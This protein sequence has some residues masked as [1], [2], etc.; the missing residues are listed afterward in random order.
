MQ[1]TLMNSRSWLNTD[2]D[3]VECMFSVPLQTQT[4][5]PKSKHERKQTNKKGQ[6]KTQNQSKEK[7]SLCKIEVNKAIALKQNEWQ[8]TIS[9]IREE[10]ETVRNKNATDQIIQKMKNS[11]D[12]LVQE[13]RNTICDISSKILGRYE[14]QARQ[15]CHSK[16]L[17]TIKRQI[18]NISNLKRQLKI[19]PEN[20]SQLNETLKYIRKEI[21]QLQGDRP[22]LKAL[23]YDLDAWRSWLDE[24][25]DETVRY[26]RKQRNELLRSWKIKDAP[27]SVYYDQRARKKFYDTFFR[28]KKSAKINSAIDPN[29]QE[30]TQDPNKYK[31]IIRNE[32][33]KGFK[34][35]YD[36]PPEVPSWWEA[37]YNPE[38]H[39]QNKELLKNVMQ[40][41]TATE[42]T[43]IINAADSHTASE[44]ELTTDLMK[45]IVAGEINNQAIMILTEL[46]NL[47]YDTMYCP[48]PLKKGKIVLLPKPGQNHS[49]E[50]EIE[51]PANKMRP[52]T[53]LP[54]LGKLPT[55][56]LAARISKVICNNPHL[57]HEA[58][59]GFIKNGNVSQCISLTLDI[60]E[61]YHE[62]KK[63]NGGELYMI[64][65]DQRKAYDSVQHYSIRASLERLNFP[66]QFIEY[67]MSTLTEAE[68]YVMT[69]QGP[70]ATFPIL[71]SV[72][73]GDPLSPL[74][75]LFVAD[76]LHEML[77][78]EAMGVGYRFSNQSDTELGYASTAYAD[79][80]TI[81]SES[82]DKIQ[83]AHHF[84]CEFFAAHRFEFNTEKTHFSYIP[85]NADRPKSLCSVA[86]YV[87]MKRQLAITGMITNMQ[88]S[89]IARPPNE[90]F[91]HLGT[92]ITLTLD[93]TKQK[94]II[95]QAIAHFNGSL[96][97]HHIDLLM[98]SNAYREYLLPKIELGLTHAEIDEK[99]L[100]AWTTT[101]LRGITKAANTRQGYSIKQSAMLSV[102]N[103]QSLLDF[104]QTIIATELMVSLN[105]QCI[106][107]S[108]RAAW[109]R[110]RVAARIQSDDLI[111][112]VYTFQATMI[113][114]Y[115]RNLIALRDT[116]LR[117]RMN[118]SPWWTEHSKIVATRTDL[119][120]IQYMESIAS[121]ER[122]HNT[123]IK[124]A[125]TR[126]Q[127]T[128]PQT[129]YTDGSTKPRG[130]APNSGFAACWK[131]QDDRMHCTSGGLRTD[132]NN[133]LAEMAGI[134]AALIIA[135]S[136]S[137]VIIKSDSQ[138]AIA[139][140]SRK[141][142]TERERIR[143]PGRAF[144]TT[145]QKLIVARRAPT[146]FQYVRAHTEQDHEDAKINDIAD[147]SAK[148]ARMLVEEIDMPY[149]SMNEETVIADIE[150]RRVNGDIRKAMKQHLA[151]KQVSEWREKVIPGHR[152]LQGEII[153]KYPTEVQRVAK[154]V[155]AMQNPT[156]LTFWLLAVT[157]WLPNNEMKTRHSKQQGWASS[158][159]WQED[160]QALPPISA[161][162]IACNESV[163]E[164]VRHIF[165]CPS[166]QFIIKHLASKINGVLTR[167]NLP[168][169]IQDGATEPSAQL[170]HSIEK[171]SQQSVKPTEEEMRQILPRLNQ[172]SVEQSEEGDCTIAA[173]EGCVCTAR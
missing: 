172:R 60:I 23:Q 69:D 65:Y 30:L 81:F 161:R 143:C 19:I 29:T 98:A 70:T 62:T 40:H 163:S 122:L 99:Q 147:K 94:D 111:A 104:R 76:A 21:F 6:I 64:S 31:P 79:D 49:S 144:V 155:R 128:T 42:L 61:D 66:L 109:H 5:K 46:V 52:I 102:C 77:N 37:V 159:N 2:H 87:Q 101:I 151:K 75:Y 113:N 80:L 134:L 90:P 153:S 116:G 22:Q 156:M 137:E 41:T 148:E 39:K 173:R 13:V 126:T 20:Q 15:P 112:M 91:R 25:A 139:T 125:E 108:T 150:G 166:T 130:T 162:C 170:K 56:I 131:G 93:W 127:Q 4:A 45:I 54:E 132:R 67:V 107:P 48:R 92:Y 115:A 133:Y 110:V 88:S 169:C 1:C 89:I 72:R 57:L 136:N 78:S 152:N 24:S 3:M 146:S 142:V 121:T 71:T 97:H 157:Q 63:D 119:S 74:L 32:I 51:Q 86:E 9:Q 44:D 135:P 105:S 103:I 55:R 47:S 149:F 14:T 28:Y 58:Q 73:Q 84:V 68:S 36:N 167:H 16:S 7:L 140:L 100:Q 33:A 12:R 38:T 145:I 17:A 85:Y 95:S 10:M 106:I 96:K 114:R 165:E 117:M 120:P 53:I 164:N 18:R 141:K 50:E 82:W 27:Q 124:L 168:K 35:K 129:I 118:P 171:A 138:A 158:P 160:P 8:K 154:Q 34:D 26:L 59:R 43:E 11:A 123:I 83:S